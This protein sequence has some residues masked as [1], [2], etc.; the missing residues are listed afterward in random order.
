MPEENGLPHIILHNLT[1]TE[2]YRYPGGGSSEKRLPERERISHADHLLAGLQQVR[3]EAQKRKED[4]KAWAI[5]AKKGTHVEFESE[6][7]FELELQ[8][9][10]KRPQGIQLV[11]VRDSPVTEGATIATVYV[12]NGQLKSFERQIREYAEQETKS[13]KPR[14]QKLVEKIAHIRLAQLRS[15]WTD[16]DELLPGAH[17][18]IWWEVWLRT[19]DQSSLESFRITMGRLGIG[20]GDKTLEFPSTR[21]LLAY[22]ALEQFAASIEAV[23][24]IAELRRAKEV[25][26][27]FMEIPRLE[28]KQWVDDLLERIQRPTDEAPRIC[29]LETGVNAGHPLLQVAAYLSDLHAVDPAWGIDDH[30]GHG[31]AMAGL[32]LY[33]DLAEALGGNQGVELAAR[34]ESVKI[35]PPPPRANHPDLYG[36]ITEQA[37]YR[38]EVSRPEALRTF[39]MAVTALD[40]R[41]RGKPSSWSAA[42]DKLA[43]GGDSEPKRLIVLAA[44]NSN[45]DAWRTYPDHLETEE[46]HDPGQAWNALTV[47]AFTERWQI[48]GE[49][50]AGWTPIAQP[51]DLS[52]STSTSSSWEAPWP[53]KP[54]VVLEGGNA[55]RSPD[56]EMVDLLDSLSLLTTYHRL[57]E[58]P[59]TMFGE[60]SAASALVARMASILQSQYSAFWPETIRA[61]IV[62]SAVW[63]STMLQRFGPENK[64]DHERLI[65]QCGFGVP[66]LQR[67][68]WS[69]NNRLTLIIQEAFQPFIQR[70]NEVTGAKHIALKEL[71]IH[72]LPWPVEQ[73]R[74]LGEVDVELRVTLS[75]FIDPNP[76]ERGYR[77]RHRYQSHGFRF[78][79]QGKN[80][81]LEDFRKRLNKA[82]RGEAE[83]SPGTSDASGWSVGSDARHHGS[84]HSDIWRGSA[85]ELANRRHI[86]VYPVTGWWK[87]QAHLGHWQKRARYALLVSIHVPQVEVDIYTPVRNIVGVP[88]EIGTS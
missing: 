16:R 40:G 78:D 33:G 63:T 15:F 43:C 82:A 17:E 60:T 25:A 50:F 67:A 72:P 80:E 27:I 18:A 66:S 64:G 19:S 20:V 21:V 1:E 54:D 35:L 37:V 61:L 83:A 48:E 57:N 36:R 68:L 3:V 13:K 44:G 26:S 69:A 38:V 12:P 47:G 41:E 31:T 74:E 29:L 42:V 55:G 73:L 28:Q 58:R 84:I 4:L 65:R 7:G 53:L 24:A 6:P 8:S 81:R 59:F 14:H 62:H 2:D 70:A 5:P 49:D 88:V 87:E 52:P 30:D 79:V 23:D 56:G 10:E 9:L 11:A 34:L 76:S 86:A 71:Q 45:R 46:I 32:G 85:A 39:V 51:G 75:Y 77:Y 22:G